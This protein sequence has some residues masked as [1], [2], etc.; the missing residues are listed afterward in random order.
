MEQKLTQAF[1]AVHMDEGCMEKVQQA[2]A[3]KKP[4]RSPVRYALRTAVAVCLVLILVVALN[5]TAAK[6]VEEIVE[7]VKAAFPWKPDTVILGDDTTYYADDQMQITQGP[8]GST[9]AL[10]TAAPTWLKEKDGRVYFLANL[11]NKDITGLFSAEEPFLYIYEKDGV[12]HHIA[13]GGDY[14]PEVGLDSVGYG[15]WLRRTDKMEEGLAEGNTHAGWIG[16][17]GSRMYQDAE[18]TLFA[19]WYAR[20]IVEMEIP[21]GNTEAKGQLEALEAAK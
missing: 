20:A 12:I 14:D 7:S 10:R 4:S 8:D 18:G 17:G 1:D 19:L 11:E 16:G 3:Q 9:G 13:V 5:P 6:A 21:W 2:M 15:E